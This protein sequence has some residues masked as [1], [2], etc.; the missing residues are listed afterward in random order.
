MLIAVL[1]GLEPDTWV[2]R[3]SFQDSSNFERYTACVHFIITTITTV[4]YG[5]ISPYTLW[6]RYIYIPPLYNYINI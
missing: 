1:E 4:G 6:E 2:I 3:Y 5:D